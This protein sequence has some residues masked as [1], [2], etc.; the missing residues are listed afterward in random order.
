MRGR[1]H[2]GCCEQSVGAPRIKS[3]VIV[4]GITISRWHRET[5]VDQQS[6][7]EDRGVIDDECFIV[8]AIARLE[9]GGRGQSISIEPSQKGRLADRQ[10]YFGRAVQSVLI[11]PRR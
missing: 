5:V 1:R 4:I 7:L 8:N 6:M 10:G 2:P 3:Q 11:E 9:L